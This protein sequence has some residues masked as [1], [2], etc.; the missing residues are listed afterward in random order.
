MSLFY[1]QPLGDKW[2]VGLG[3]FNSFGLAQTYDNWVGRYYVQES[4]LVG[5]SLMPSISFKATDWLSFSYSLNAMYG[6]I[7]NQVAINNPPFA[8]DGQMKYVDGDR[9][10]GGNAGILIE[11]LK[12]TR[13]GITYTSPVKFNFSDQPT[14]TGLGGCSARS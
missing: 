14:F 12:G 7:N 2:A 10:F 5:V 3:T 13:F 4:A 9:G 1:V 6:Y 8:S 11:P